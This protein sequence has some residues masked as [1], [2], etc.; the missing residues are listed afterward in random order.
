MRRLLLG[1]LLLVSCFRARPSEGGGQD[2]SAPTVRP[3]GTTNVRLPAGY[4]IEAVAR[5]LTFPSGVA[6]DD[7]GTPFVIEAGYSYGDA[8]VTPRLLRVA[9]GAV[10]EVAAG[11]NGPWNG[12]AYSHGAFFVAEGGEKDGG[13]ILRIEP[14]GKTKTL[15]E[16]LPSLGDHHTNGPAI[17]PDGFVYFGQGTATNS[18]VV[19]E[20]AAQYGWL[21]R[22]PELHDL[23]CRDVTLAG[24]NYESKDPRKPDTRVSTG[25]YLPFGQKSE[26]GQVIKGALPCS[27]A[28]MKIPID[29]GEPQL[30]AWGFRNPFGLAFA[31]DGQL[32]VTDNGFD[33]RGSRPVWGVADYLWA[34]QANAWY[35]WPDFAGGEQ[36]D[37]KRFAVPGMAPPKLLL[38]HAPGT[39]PM[40][41]AYFGVHSSSN[42]LDFSRN[43]AFGHQGEAFVAQFGDLSPSTG[44]L[45]APVGFK[46]VR[47]DPKTAVITD[48]AVND[49]EQNGPASKLGKDGLERPVACRFDPSGMAL[50]VVDFG[51]M[52]IDE[53]GPAPRVKSGVLWK[54][55]REGSS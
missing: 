2:V 52:I 53:K 49:G 23:P 19:G 41:S 6:F 31:P 44:K 54:I 5:D 46:V 29:G 36:I 16:G 37:K 42:G 51:V 12:I 47:V 30:V 17:G 38:D 33:V 8:F 14:D 11:K 43:A 4:R 34:V 27:G 24:V 18:G 40:P 15:I 7:A 50:Y 32:F 3:I 1:S 22:H 20:D 28:I 35:G 48:F 21:S 25:A 39:P 26:K 45:L 9:G 10:T 13:R 55:T